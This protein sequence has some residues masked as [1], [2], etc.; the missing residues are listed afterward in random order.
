MSDDWIQTF[1]T[2]TGKDQTFLNFLHQPPTKKSCNKTIKAHVCSATN[3]TTFPRKLKIAP[4]ALPTV[5]SNSSTAFPASLLS[6][7]ASLSSHFF[8]IPSSFGGG[9]PAS[10]P[11]QKIP[12]M[13]SIIVEIVIEKAVSFENILMPCSE[14]KVRILSANDV[15]RSRTF[16]RVCLILVTCV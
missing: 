9:P 16:S 13:A 14:N 11:P 7:F 3:P 5:A 4:I 8:N 1:L 15:L 6:V 2:S 12:V 10:P